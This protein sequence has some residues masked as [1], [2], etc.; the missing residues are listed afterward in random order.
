MLEYIISPS[1]NRMAI[2]K[3]MNGHFHIP[4]ILYSKQMGA[5]HSTRSQLK[6]DMGVPCVQTVFQSPK[7]RFGFK[8]KATL[9]EAEKLNEKWTDFTSSAKED[10]VYYTETQKSPQ[11]IKISRNGDK[12]Q[13]NVSTTMILEKEDIGKLTDMFAEATGAIKKYYAVPGKAGLSPKEK[14]SSVN[15]LAQDK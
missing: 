5:N 1:I 10:F 9:E 6:N 15:L 3:R 8:M 2:A 13:I 11:Y 7:F 12:L 4:N 14:S